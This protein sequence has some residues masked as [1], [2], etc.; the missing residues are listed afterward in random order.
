M[1]QTVLDLIRAFQVGEQNEAAAIFIDEDGFD[2]VTIRVL[3]AWW[4]S[5]HDWVKPSR[6]CPDDGR[7]T[8]R[9]YAWLI[10]GMDI[11]YVAIAD[12]AGVSRSQA[13]AR[14]ARLIGN[15]LIY[16]D[17]QMAK[18]AKA[19]MQAAIAKRVRSAV[20]K[21]EEQPKKAGAN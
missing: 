19:S 13:R 18:V 15:R 9:A 7:P 14:M 4:H 12:A 3:S 10:S 11:D 5:D 8:A 20:K 17:G 2:L 21:A 6:P 16:P 1:D